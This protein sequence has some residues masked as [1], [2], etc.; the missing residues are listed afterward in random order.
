MELET[1]KRLVIDR[2]LELHDLLMDERNDIKW[3]NQMIQVNSDILKMLNLRVE[4][5]FYKQDFD[6]VSVKNFFLYPKNLVESFL[7]DKN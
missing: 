2:L 7:I 5:R 6:I 4:I 3:I 1:K